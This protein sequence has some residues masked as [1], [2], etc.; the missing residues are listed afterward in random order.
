MRSARVLFVSLLLSSAVTYAVDD[1]STDA[2][3]SSSMSLSRES[4]FFTEGWKPF[5]GLSSGYMSAGGDA[6]VEGIPTSIKALG[7]YYT[8]DTSWVFDVGGGIQHQPMSAGRSA[9]VPLLEASARYQMGEGWQLG[10]VLNTYLGDSNRYTSANP[11]FT[12]L[13]GV[14]MNKDFLWQGQLLRAGGAAMTDLDISRGQVLALMANLQMSFGLSPAQSQPVSQPV[15][16]VPA[17][18]ETPKAAE[19]LIRQA[20]LTPPPQKPLAQFA[21]QSDALSAPDRTYLRRVASLLR[22][23]SSQ[24]RSVTLVGHT[25]PTGPESL[26]QKLSVSRAKAVKAYL[27]RQGVPETKLVVT[28]RSSREPISPSLDPNR[29]V[30]IKFTSGVPTH[31]DN[32]LR[33]LE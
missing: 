12:S 8:E 30:E 22:M 7:S 4:S 28:G 23:N 33:S 29:R 9:T 31:L 26:N 27:V 2:S 10:P 15:V 11:N 5:V 21:L 18:A 32:A 13:V 25:D 14:A 3:K 6:E 1:A 19:H 20:Q 24:Y 16:E 17:P